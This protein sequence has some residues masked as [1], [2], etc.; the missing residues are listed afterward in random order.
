MNSGICQFSDVFCYSGSQLG[1]HVRTKWDSVEN[2][3]SEPLRFTEV[4]IL[5]GRILMLLRS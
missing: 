3:D 4:K 1:V 2:T 5:W